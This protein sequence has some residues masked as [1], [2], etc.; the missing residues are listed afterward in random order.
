MTTRFRHNQ[1]KGVFFIIL[2]TI[3]VFAAN[4]TQAQSFTRSSYKAY[5]GF[6]ASF[7]TRSVN[8]SSNIAKI[9]QTNLMATGGQAGVIFGNN[10]VR[11]K[12]G[13]LGYYSSAGNTAG[14]T[15]LYE[16]NASVNFYPLSL[17]TSNNYLI[18]PYFTGGVSFDRFKFFGFYIN[19]EPGVT[20]Y[21]Q[22]EAPYLGKIKQVNATIGLGIE[23]KLKDKFD[24]IHLFSEVKYG[25]NLSNQALNNTIAGTSLN[26][27]M[28]VVLGV[29]FGAIR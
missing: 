9:N 27:Q 29:S 20:N 8:V 6:V 5:R 22:S 10:T 28:Q 25:H 11:A 23:V 13:L 14:T 26:N 15:D 4:V 16:S 2:F 7:G 21:S 3:L 1:I 19:Q 12:I 24:F 17:I 18:A